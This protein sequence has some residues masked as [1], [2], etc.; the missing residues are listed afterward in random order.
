VSDNRGTIPAV[1]ATKE[2]TQ[3]ANKGQEIT[4]ITD[5]LPSYIEAI[6]FLNKEREK[7]DKIRHIQFFRPYYRLTGLTKKSKNTLLKSDV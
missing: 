1:A 2:A 7:D 3:T 6:R 5:G 4:L